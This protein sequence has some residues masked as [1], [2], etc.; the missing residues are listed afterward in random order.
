MSHRRPPDTPAVS[1]EQQALQRKLADLVRKRQYGQALRLREQALRRHPDW[2]LSPGEAQL[3]CLE[4]QQALEQQQLKHA[5]AAFRRALAVDPGGE[6]LL[7]MV[8]LRLQQQLPQQALQLL[9]QA[10]A[11]GQLDP[12][13]AGVLLKLLLLQGQE[14]RLRSLLREQPQ[15]FQSHQI[16]WASGVL[17]L[18]D[19]HPQQARRQFD[20]MAAPATPGDHR[21]VWRAW[22]LREAGDLPAAAAALQGADHPACAALALDLAA[23]SDQHPAAL[24][25]GLRCPPPEPELAWALELLHQLRHNRPIPAAELLLAHE[26]SLL[27][28]LPE[29]ASLRR[30][31]LLQAG[32]EALEREAPQEAIRFWRPLVEPPGFDADLALRLYP[33]L[34]DAGDE[35]ELLEAERL[36]ASLLGWLR[37]CARD[38]PQ[39]WP[40]PRLSTTL[41]RL[42]CWQ[43]HAQMRLGMR[44]QARRSVE[45]A[46][47]LAPDHA[48]VL[49]ARGLLAVMN[50][51]SAAAIPL[52][53]QALDGGCSNPAVFHLL[54]EELDD[55]G[56]TEER[57]RLLHDHGLRF[58][59]ASSPED[60]AETG[61]PL[62]LEALSQPDALTMAN[63]LRANPAAGGGGI[64]SL[65]IFLDHAS[66]SQGSGSGEAAAVQRRK[67]SLA[68]AE[69]RPR[70]DALLAAL[71]PL[72]RV[73]A[74]TAIVAVILRFCRRGGKSLS[75]EISARL[76]QL[77]QLADSKG[78]PEADQALRAL[79]LL[80]GLGLKRGE[81][82]EPQARLLLR[83]SP[84]PERLLALALLDLRLLASTRPWQPL[85]LDLQ[86]RDPSNPLLTLALASM[87]RSGSY[88]YHCL[89]KDAFDQARRLQ[90][91]EGLA[92][93]RREQAWI[94]AEQE[95]ELF[96]R[97]AR[98]LAD[99]P[100][101]QQRLVRLD[102]RKL[103][104]SMVAEQG[105]PDCSE[106]WID[107]MLPAFEQQ[108]RTLF[109]H[110]GPAEFDRQL[111]EMAPAPADAE[112][113]H[114]RKR[115]D[116][117]PPHPQRR[118]RTFMDL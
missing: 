53:R 73:Q 102:L 21:A 84:Q 98:Q 90:D 100:A 105:A 39:A 16:H 80:H 7:G 36:A 37:R 46:R 111:L 3:C 94:E 91:K 85:L 81:S 117:P 104:R 110:L 10:F 6:G 30:P 32:Q 43:A 115:D 56:Q 96:H 45:Q 78:L 76:L 38:E 34:I 64:A 108:I 17:N 49:G 88:S 12:N 55:S 26:R 15:R 107:A 69:A 97:Q 103:L 89:S 60:E 58:G 59:V 44:Q 118:R 2:S 57:R 116:P 79:L 4:G 23:R 35:D 47:Q 13:H 67:L 65:Q 40:E 99:D 52:L 63:A 42:H 50:G 87:E 54:E 74:L 61:H 18:L 9:E 109:V 11:A 41:A 33:L 82:P 66:S 28:V 5:E 71:Q 27:A 101:W 106:A 72:E 92:A 83:R 24:L 20:Q 112:P 19:G 48:D 1:G 114:R 31:L 113:D 95:R 86:R 93:C 77:E 70:W 62:W 8:R 75:A 68:L 22:A 29:L 14:Q 25:S 51:A